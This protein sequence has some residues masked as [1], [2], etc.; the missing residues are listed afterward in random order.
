MRASKTG[1]RSYYYRFSMNGKQRK[2]FLGQLEDTYLNDAAKQH[3]ELAK[4]VKAGVDAV[5]E[6]QIAAKE[7]Q[8]KAAVPISITVKQLVERWL[9]D[10][11]E[12]NAKCCSYGFDDKVRDKLVDPTL[13][14][15]LKYGKN[16]LYRVFANMMM[17]SN[18]KDALVLPPDDRRMWVVDTHITP[19]SEE[20]YKSLYGDL[21][22]R[23]FLTGV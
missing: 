10:H 14:L 1:G 9:K 20:Y 12:V 4:Q 2:I 19:R 21:D 13:F 11:L 23:K 15:N 22:D 6:R 16:G 7:L 17:F 8:L 3:A 5:A 18:N